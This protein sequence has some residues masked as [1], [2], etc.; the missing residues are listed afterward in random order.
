MNTNIDEFDVE[1]ARSLLVTWTRQRDAARR[2][3]EHFERIA[4]GL[5]QMING[6]ERIFPEL[7]NPPGVGDVPAADQKEERV[8]DTQVETAGRGRP[9]GMTSVDAVASVVNDD[10]SD[11]WL[12]VQQIVREMDRRGW[13]PDAEVPEAAI[14]TALAR[15]AAKGK[16]ESVQLDGRTKGYRRLLNAEAPVTAGASASIPASGAGGD[17]Y[18]P[19]IDQDRRDPLAEWHNDNRDRGASVEETRF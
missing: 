19:Q 12:T 6:V 2:Q 9:H 16:I 13:T 17:P 11:A 7:A 5:T 10:Q 3:R 8:S 15:A 14:R 4:M 1:Q 18:A